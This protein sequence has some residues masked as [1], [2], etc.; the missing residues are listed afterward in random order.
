MSIVNKYIKTRGFYK[1]GPVYEVLKLRPDVP[2]IF[3]KFLTHQERKLWIHTNYIYIYNTAFEFSYICYSDEN[4]NLKKKISLDNFKSIRLE[5]D[6]CTLY[7]SIKGGKYNSIEEDDRTYEF[8]FDS[9]DDAVTMQN[10]IIDHANETKF[11]IEFAVEMK[12]DTEMMQ[13]T[14]NLLKFISKLFEEKVS[15]KEELQ[16]ELKDLDKELAEEE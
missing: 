10:N 4:G 3:P 11:I 2:K 13:K 8:I 7:L 15:D 12:E 9:F 5:K 14:R 6:T 1:N 16:A